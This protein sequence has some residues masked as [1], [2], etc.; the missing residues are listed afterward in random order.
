MPSPSLTPTPTPAPNPP[1]PASTPV[2]VELKYDNGNDASFMSSAGGGYLVDFMPPSTPMKITKIK[3]YGG[4]FGESGE[5]KKFLL[6]IWDKDEKVFYESTI[7]VTKFQTGLNTVDF[8]LGLGSL[9]WVDLEI[10]LS[11]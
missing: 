9:N 2:E 7:P 5:G 11:K 3:L 6:Q 4:C 10:P 8:P 1:P